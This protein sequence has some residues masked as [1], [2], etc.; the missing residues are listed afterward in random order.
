MNNWRVPVPVRVVDVDVARP[1]D[2]L[3]DLG[4][5]V[6][7][8][9]IVRVD[10][11]PVGT[12]EAPVVDGRSSARY[13]CGEINASLSWDIARVRLDALISGPP[14]D[15]SQRATHRIE[16]LAPAPVARRRGEPLSVT[17][18][19]C[20]RDRPE[21]L[22]QTLK[23]L[24]A[25]DHECEILVVDN[26]PSSDATERLV[27]RFPA[28]RYVLEPRPGLDWARNRAIAEA[29]GEVVAFTD[30]DAVVD[31]RWVG[32]LA[33]VFASDADVMA[34][35]GLVV[36][37][38]LDTEA[39]VWF[40][41]YGGFGRGFQRR[42]IRAAV[43]PDGVRVGAL[44][45]TGLLGTGANMAFRRSVFADVGLFDP[46]LDVGTR[47]NGAGDLDMFFRVLKGG[48]TLVY[49]PAA[50]VRHRHR[51]T[52][53]ELR[54]QIRAHGSLYS[55]LQAA[56]RRAPDEA[57][58]LRN[59]AFRW[60]PLH[61]VRRLSRS[62]AIPGWMPPSLVLDEM[63]GEVAAVLGAEY[64][65]ARRDA[66]NIERSHGPLVCALPSPPGRPAVPTAAMAVRAVDLRAGISGLTDLDGY[67][68]VRCFVC[69]GTEPIGV[70]DVYDV[71]GH[72]SGLELRD[73]LVEQLRFDVIEA[74]ERDV[75]RRTAINM[76]CWATMHA[77]AQPSPEAVTRLNQHEPSRLRVAV[78]LATLD[79]PDDLRRCLESLTEQVQR[80]AAEVIVCDNNPSSGL[81][82]GVVAAFPWA[83]LVGEPRRGAA[84]A[85]NRAIL[86][87]TADVVAI[88]DD[89][90]VAQSD[91]LDHL[92]ASFG[93]RDVMAVTGN[94]L[95]AEMD[96]AA[97]RSFEAHQSLGRGFQRWEANRSWFV[98][99]QRAVP[100]WD[101]GGT[102][103]AAFRM[104]ALQ[105]PEIGLMDEAL[106]PGMPTGVGEDSYLLY[107]VLK[108]GFT[109]V[110]EP[111]A[112]VWHYHRR[113]EKSFR[114]QIYGYYKGT[115]S[116]QLA[117]L[118]RDHDLRAVRHLISTLP[119]WFR[120]ERRAIRQGTSAKSMDIWRIQARGFA[121]GPTG[122][123]RARLRVRKWGPSEAVPWLNEPGDDRAQPVAANG[124]RHGVGSTTEQT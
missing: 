41:R 37:L 95:P 60:E 114:R 102:C 66:M 31:S 35:T 90:A 124:S 94:V 81:T 80:H 110:Y 36:P 120:Q 21:G 113:D 101:L 45:A 10:G 98:W 88:I 57:T 19:V 2:D 48:W 76:A 84:Y 14:G 64:K 73:A 122:Y 75:S 59:L 74:D 116:H 63:R 1:V 67:G 111:S 123:V 13:I 65:R 112:V 97:Q 86:A 6:S 30:D 79:R 121:A 104:S 109:V 105:D 82:P 32:A 52:I 58:A 4:D 12:I 83:R 51:R 34:V 38:E 42:W 25:L 20:S 16:D 5:A 27:H 55:Y 92:L 78:V 69:H 117:T 118:H 47:T 11:V 56:R 22:E 115:A 119:D 43:T 7:V 26:A 54:R 96:T 8:H 9:V 103:N 85:R 29:R 46:A 28:V 49:E 18:A 33:E 23:S 44:A 50:L 68:S 61:H 17:V 93:R 106:G 107:R 100:T 99:G 89:D 53:P 77:A 87:A 62:F 40:E 39:Q 71:R 3:T 24:Q 91:W 108:A 70:V 15:G 72:V